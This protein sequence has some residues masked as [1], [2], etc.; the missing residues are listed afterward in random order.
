MINVRPASLPADC[1]YVAKTWFSQTLSFTHSYHFQWPWLYLTWL[2]CL[3]WTFYVL[4][5]V[6]TLYS[7]WLH[8]VDHEYMYTYDFL[9]SWYLTYPWNARVVRTPQMI[10]QP[11]SSI[12]P[13]SPLPSGTCQI[14]GLSI[15]WGSLPATSSVCLIVFPLSLCLARWFW[16]ELMNRR[17]DHTSAFCIS[18]RW[19]GGLQ[20]VRLPAWSWHSNMI[21]V[22]D[23]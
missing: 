14:L 12:F 18:L 9:L 10:L 1:P 3:N 13:C 19:S 21:F 11:V 17:Y 16:P 15:P 8:Q 4:V 5:K 6:Q 2:Y 22:R 23:V 20:V 7:C